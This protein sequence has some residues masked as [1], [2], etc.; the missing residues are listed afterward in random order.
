MIFFFCLLARALAR[1]WMFAEKRVF[2]PGSSMCDGGRFLLCDT[3]ES[4]PKF[5]GETPHN[6]LLVWKEHRIT[7]WMQFVLRRETVGAKDF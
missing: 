7:L 6:T 2:S 3:P 5:G 4:L 1:E